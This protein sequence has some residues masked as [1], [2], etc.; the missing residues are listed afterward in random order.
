MILVK[1]IERRSDSLMI[2]YRREQNHIDSLHDALRRHQQFV[3]KG[4]T[5]TGA[6]T[7]E[8]TQCTNPSTE[9]LIDQGSQLCSVTL[10]KKKTPNVNT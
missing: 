5:T 4:S 6:H 1:K 9:S 3:I 8:L 10:R 2:S 7:Q